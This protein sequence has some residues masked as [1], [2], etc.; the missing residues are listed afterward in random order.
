LMRRRLRIRIRIVKSWIRIQIRIKVK[1]SIRIRIKNGCG[2]ETLAEI[3][4]KASCKYGYVCI[5]WSRNNKQV[6]HKMVRCQGNTR[7]SGEAWTPFSRSLQK[8]F[9][10]MR[11][12]AALLLYCIS[13][14][15]QKSSGILF[16][17]HRGYSCTS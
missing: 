14:E 17:L 3:G 12:L 1:S 4:Q 13:D 15:G 2:S 5:A 6:R 16:R 8:K 7:T 10:K 11:G 9:G